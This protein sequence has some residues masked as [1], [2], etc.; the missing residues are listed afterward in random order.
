MAA[1]GDATLSIP[2]PKRS[3]AFVLSSHFM[4]TATRLSSDCCRI[5]LF[6]NAP[7]AFSDSA[8]P[9]RMQAMLV[10]T[11]PWLLGLTLF[12][13]IIHTVFDL[14]AFKNDIQFWKGRKNF[15]GV[16]VYPYLWLPI[17]VFVCTCVGACTRLSP[18]VYLCVTA[19]LLGSISMRLLHCLFAAVCIYHCS[20]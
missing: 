7:I 2:V 16:R 5:V 15:E 18:H 19:L 9:C 14:L 13:S 20:C 3:I 12:I 6:L 17:R 4:R 1:A 8:V 11:N 10:D